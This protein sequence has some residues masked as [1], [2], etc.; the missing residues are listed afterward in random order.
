MTV[1]I[2]GGPEEESSLDRTH[3]SISSQHSF[4][5]RSR[6]PNP[7]PSHMPQEMNP[8]H[9][10]A[11]SVT[12]SALS[13]H[14]H[15]GSDHRRQQSF[16]MAMGGKNQ[17]GVKAKPPVRMMGGQA[18]MHTAQGM[19]N[20]NIPEGQK[21]SGHGYSDY[22]LSTSDQ[23][24]RP[25]MGGFEPAPLPLTPNMKGYQPES[26]RRDSFNKKGK[27]PVRADVVRY[28]MNHG[29]LQG[30]MSPPV[31]SQGVQPPELPPKA[32][33]S[34]LFYQGPGS[35]A[36]SQAHIRQRTLSQG[37]DEA[38]ASDSST[39]EGHGHKGHTIVKP[40]AAGHVGYDHRHSHLGD[41]GLSHS[42]HTPVQSGL[43]T[44]PRKKKEMTVQHQLHQ[45]QGSGLAPGT[46]ESTTSFSKQNSMGNLIPDHHPRSA[47]STS[48]S[49]VVNP[50][51]LPPT[52]PGK[53]LQHQDQLPSSELDKKSN[54]KKLKKELKRA[55][56]KQL[57]SSYS[58]LDSSPSP[59]PSP[60]TSE[61][62]PLSLPISSSSN[63][64]Q[65]HGAPPLPHHL[66][67]ENKEKLY[68]DRRMV[69][70]ILK[71]Q[72]LQRQPSTNSNGSSSSGISGVSNSTVESDSI[73]GRLLAAKLGEAAVTG[74]S[75]DGS[76]D[77][78]S[79]GSHKDSG[80]GG[81]D[82]NSSSSTGSG[83][84]DPYTQYFIS[85]SMVVPRNLNPQVRC[86]RHYKEVF[87]VLSDA[88]LFKN[89]CGVMRHF[90]FHFDLFYTVVNL[91]KNVVLQ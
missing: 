13:E 91:Y 86:Y 47:S 89:M 78:V 62:P 14:G 79:I 9:P 24:R 45:R 30:A 76:F 32:S 54:S 84:I 18:G 87:I 58:K 49:S 68:I 48:S 35:G 36:P 73:M 55:E 67:G 72:G 10:R 75:G 1:L 7:E 43:A 38:Y 17:E 90:T 39:Y 52:V 12:P 27:E 83:T 88:D 59:S 77:N 20:P 11:R 74:Q 31:L 19:A 61:A 28:Q 57:K 53:H 60:S 25:S 81:S 23:Y 33:S 26:Q 85:K 64:A 66:P 2:Q 37:G 69:E 80:Y 63:V 4:Q 70:S 3:E 16:I 44:L 50:S 21:G 46:Q 40:M 65:E 15:D 82:R 5:H 22:T 42:S 56:K 71:H 29:R 51:G 6:T 8:A 34:A 41:G